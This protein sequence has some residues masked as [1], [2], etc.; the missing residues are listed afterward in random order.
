M[1]VRTRWWVSAVRS[2][3]RANRVAK[4]VTIR[5]WLRPPGAAVTARTP[6]TCASKNCWIGAT[7][8][9]FS[10][11]GEQCIRQ[12][13]R[14]RT[15]AEVRDKLQALHREPDACVRTDVNGR[16]GQFCWHPLTIGRDPVYGH[17]EGA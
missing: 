8:L 2:P 4:A 5:A 16:S 6:S 11:D 12:K 14:G 3:G 15:K 13:V 7:S 1:S 17:S 9:E 10:P